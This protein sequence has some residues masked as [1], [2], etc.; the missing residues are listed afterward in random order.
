MKRVLHSR[1]HPSVAFDLALLVAL[2]GAIST[3]AAANAELPVAIRTFNYA[4]FPAEQLASARLSATIIF[5]R[6][7]I[8]LHWIDCW[9]PQS[10]SGA[11]CTQ[12]LGDRGD[13]M[14]R[15]MD[16][17]PQTTGRIVPLGTSMLDL[18]QRAG[19][20]MTIDAVPIRAIAEKTSTDVSTLLGRA[21]A[22]EIGHLLLGSP[23]HTKTGLMRAFWSQEELQGLKPVHWQFTPYEAAQMR[24]GLAIKERAN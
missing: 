24:H 2:A 4:Q 12:P 19:V 6:A 5:K 14:L 1:H 9:V 8:S 13:L 3:N 20:L 10:N 7:G 18:E 17:A 11:A 23:E 21:I 15:L 22:H 16:I